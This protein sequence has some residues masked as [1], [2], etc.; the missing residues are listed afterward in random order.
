MGIQQQLLCSLVDD[1]GSRLQ[2]SICGSGARQAQKSS[3][4]SQLYFQATDGIVVFSDL[5]RVPERPQTRPVQLQEQ[6]LTWLLRMNAQLRL[7]SIS[8]LTGFGEP[9]A[10]VI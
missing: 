2:A 7:L 1:H 5:A 9:S 3:D 8:D 6:G 10:I 4:H